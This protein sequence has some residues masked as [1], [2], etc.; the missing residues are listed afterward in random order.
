MGPGIIRSAISTGLFMEPIKPAVPPMP[1][2]PGVLSL[3]IGSKA[4]LFSSYM[5]HLRRGGLFI[6]TNRPYN[7][8][9]EV[10]ILISLM[11]DPAKYPMAG[12]VAWITPQ[13]AQNSRPQGVGVHF[14]DDD[15]GKELRRKIEGILAG[16][17]SNRPTHTI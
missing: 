3:N 10:F 8:G 15:S 11:D 5:P 4:G 14:N 2:R 12:K 7:I 9:D 13:G 16:V 6:P 1:V 17:T